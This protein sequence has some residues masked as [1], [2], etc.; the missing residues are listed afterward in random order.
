MRMLILVC[1][2]LL[3]PAGGVLAQ[4]APDAFVAK[5]HELAHRQRRIILNDDGNVVIYYPKNLPLTAENV[6]VQRTSP[7]LGSQVDSLFYCPISSG[8]SYFTHNTKVGTVLEHP[9]ADKSGDYVPNTRNI[10]RDLI[11][12]GTDALKMIVDFARANH[13]HLEQIGRA[14]V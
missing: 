13:D 12:Q 11:N 1:L 7:L 8:F 9:I 4:A 10:T 2:A 3:C 6:L 5:R 14:H